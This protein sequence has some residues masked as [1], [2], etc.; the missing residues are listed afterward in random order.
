M[1]IFEVAILEITARVQPTL[2][3]VCYK[4]WM[5]AIPQLSLNICE[6]KSSLVYVQQ[7]TCRGRGVAHNDTAG[8]VSRHRGE[9]NLILAQANFK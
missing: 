8:A 7:W 3:Y 1:W 2:L 6:Y 5:N 9:E 4:I